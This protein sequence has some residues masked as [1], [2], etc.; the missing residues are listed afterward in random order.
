[1]EK[2]ASVRPKR[3]KAGWQ[4]WFYKCGQRESDGHSNV[5]HAITR[6]TGVWETRNPF[7]G[8]GSCR[9]AGILPTAIPKHRRPP[10]T[11]AFHASVHFS[12]IVTL[13]LPHRDIQRILYQMAARTGGWSIQLKPHGNNTVEIDIL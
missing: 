4:S 7:A 13:R 11:H 3:E 10:V 5:P 8:M 12:S 1:M 2:R 6:M 9:N